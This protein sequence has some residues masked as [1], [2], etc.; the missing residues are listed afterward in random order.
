[1]ARIIAILVVVC[2]VCAPMSSFAAKG[3]KKGP[4]DKAYEKADDNAKFKRD[5]SS[6]DI[7]ETPKKKRKRIE[8]EEGED[9]GQGQ[10]K[11][12]KEN[13]RKEGAQDD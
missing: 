12:K 4:A 5:D 6:E 3:G 11:Q 7:D 2:F 9:K 1:M 10:K 13:K 8:A